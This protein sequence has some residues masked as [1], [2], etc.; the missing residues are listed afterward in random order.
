MNI[1]KEIFKKSIANVKMLKDYSFKEK[2]GIFEYSKLFLKQFRADIFVDGQSNVKGKIFDLAFDDEYIA[3]RLENQTGSFVSSV[4]EAYKNILIDIKKHCFETTYF[5]SNQ[6]NRI[7]SK[8]IQIYNNKPEFLW[9]KSPGNGIFRSPNSRKWYAIILDVNHRKIDK[10]ANDETVEI[11]NLKLNEK[12]VEFLIKQKG[13]YPAYHMNKRNW[14]T[15]IL[16]ESLSDDQIL[17]YVAISNALT[18]K[19]NEW[20][21]PANPNFFD[22][23][24]YFNSSE[25]VEW[26]QSNNIKVGDIIYTYITQPYSAILYQHKVIEANVPYYWNGALTVRKVMKLK[27]IRKYNKSD[28]T[29]LKLNEYGVKTIRGPRNVP[30]KLSEELNK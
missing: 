21:I 14:I 17:E 16:D 8:I 27:L 25:I 9:E 22:V 6:A 19:S 3:F 24:S 29:L 15:I 23:I 13:F 11:I 20:I 12:Q 7:T 2:D 30:A 18:N 4:R 26:K 5:Q 10:D 28:F 1:E